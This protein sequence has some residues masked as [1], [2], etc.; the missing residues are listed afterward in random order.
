MQCALTN[1][2]SIIRILQEDVYSNKFDWKK[3]LLEAIE[4]CIESKNPLVTFICKKNE[5]SIYDDL[6]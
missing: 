4:D 5:Y 3:E 6:I 2:F 1:G